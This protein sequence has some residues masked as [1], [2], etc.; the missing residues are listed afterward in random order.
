MVNIMSIWELELLEL[1]LKISIYEKAT[2]SDTP[3]RIEFSLFLYVH[4]NKLCNAQQIEKREI[5]VLDLWHL[6]F[7]ALLAA[8]PPLPP[9]LPPLDTNTE[10]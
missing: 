4:G 10:L 6:V 5:T 3:L 1:R 9:S 2:K 7:G 8:C